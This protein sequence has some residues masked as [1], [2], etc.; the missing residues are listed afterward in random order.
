MKDYLDLLGNCQNK[1]E[2]RGVRK[3]I[4]FCKQTDLYYDSSRLQVFIQE[5]ENGIKNWGRSVSSKAVGVAQKHYDM[6]RKSIG[7]E[8]TPKTLAKFY[9]MKYNNKKE[10]ALLQGYAKAVEKGH[11]S[12]LIGFDFYKETAAKIERDLVGIT[13]PNEVLIRDYTTHFVDRVIGQMAEPRKGIRTGV[14]INDIADTL[15]KPVYVSELYEI[16]M[17]DR[18]DTRCTLKSENCSVSISVS[19]GKLIQTNL[20]GK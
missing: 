19:E 20:G 6:W 3:G 14:P 18:I 13:T 17:K 2:L 12:P 4:P 9:E 5:T 16:E 7:A 10:Y 11:I 15:K 8:N 1:Y